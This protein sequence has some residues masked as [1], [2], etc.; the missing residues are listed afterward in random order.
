[1]GLSTCFGPI[2]VWRVPA[3]VATRRKI[4]GYRTDLLGSAI[5]AICKVARRVRRRRSACRRVCISRGR[6][7]FGKHWG[8]RPL[9]SSFVPRCQGERG[10]QKYTGAPVA[11]VN[12]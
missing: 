5:G 12:S 2:L 11:A 3:I 9:V 6:V 7:G 8:R 4:S 1:M 10:P